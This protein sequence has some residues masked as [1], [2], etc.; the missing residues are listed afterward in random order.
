MNS[1]EQC[2][3]RYGANIQRHNVSKDEGR[4]IIDGF[5]IGSFTEPTE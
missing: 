1:S 3:Q 4:A 2:L 5:L